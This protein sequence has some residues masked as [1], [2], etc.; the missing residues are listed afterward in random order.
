MLEL[1]PVI[2]IW[3]AH[4]SNLS[5]IL[6]QSMTWQWV[7][8]NPGRLIGLQSKECLSLSET[9]RKYRQT[10]GLSER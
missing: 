1:G 2:V 4:A 10:T 8:A 5:A 3:N 6:P 7:W 9:R